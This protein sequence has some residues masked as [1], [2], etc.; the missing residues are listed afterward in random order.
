MVDDDQV[1][2][3]QHVAADID[4]L[5]AWEREHGQLV[6]LNKRNYLWRSFY[7][8]SF[9]FCFFITYSACLHATVTPLKSYSIGGSVI[10]LGR[11]YFNSTPAICLWLRCII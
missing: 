8:I 2:G 7:S 1:E 6:N 4:D 5:Q 11:G 3:E 10:G 9:L